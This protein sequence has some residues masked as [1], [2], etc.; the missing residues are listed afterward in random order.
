[1]GINQNRNYNKIDRMIKYLSR[2]SRNS[3]RFSS[4]CLVLSTIL[5]LVYRKEIGEA[6][7]IPGAIIWYSIIIGFFSIIFSIITIVILMI[8]YLSEKQNLWEFVKKEIML[9]ILTTGIF[10]IFGLLCFLMNRTNV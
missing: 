7:S 8:N 3:L 10:L 1:M 2:Y 6:Y 5:F 9:L 4:V